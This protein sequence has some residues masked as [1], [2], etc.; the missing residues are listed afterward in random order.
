MGVG[1]NM[2]K[3]FYDSRGI[4]LLLLSVGAL[5]L[6]ACAT[7][8]SPEISVEERAIARWDTILSDD[9]AGAYE[10]LSPG[11]RSSVS[12]VQ[13]QRSL[14]LSKVRWNDARYIESDCTETACNVKISLKYTVFGA[15][16]GIK[17]FNGK[18]T[19]DESWVLVDGNWY[20]V[21]DN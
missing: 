19:I 8:T 15:V 17:S 13:Y 20:L 14:L 5:L 4:S 9:L 6:S 16:P 2:I 1:T 10:Y 3:F 21:P 12:S 7:T 11:Y 18:Q